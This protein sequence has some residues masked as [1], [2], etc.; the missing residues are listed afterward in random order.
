[1]GVKCDNYSIINLVVFQCF[2][3]NFFFHKMKFSSV[4]RVHLAESMARNRGNDC[5][6]KYSLQYL[7]P[8]VRGLIFAVSAGERIPPEF[9]RVVLSGCLKVAAL[10]I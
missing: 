5:S 10:L 6:A 2:I 1:M 8:T 3:I 9:V 4:G 7:R